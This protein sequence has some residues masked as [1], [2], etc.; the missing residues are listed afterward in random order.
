MRGDKRAEEPRAGSIHPSI[1]HL[2]PREWNGVGR[3]KAVG[4]A[5][6]SRSELGLVGFMQSSLT[7]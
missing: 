7:Y 6:V 3:A 5:E 4:L 2:L 1:H